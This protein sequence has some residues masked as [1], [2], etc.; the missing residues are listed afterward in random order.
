MPIP[1]LTTQLLGVLMALA[2]AAT[3]GGSDFS[4]GFASRYNNSILVL[5]V[6]AGS[7]LAAMLVL[8]WL[9]PKEALSTADAFWAA[10][11][12]VAGGLGLVFLYRGL[13]LGSA[14]LVSPTAAV[15]GAGLP[16]LA[17]AI[18]EGLPSAL[19]FLGFVV[20]MGGIWLVSSS[21][22]G[23]SD[24]RRLHKLG[25]AAAA[26][27]C[28]GGFYISLSQVA[29][30]HV[31]APLAVTKAVQLILASAAIWLSRMKLNARQGLWIALLAGVLDAGGNS[32]Y[33]LAQQLTRLDVAA[34]LASMYPAGT[35]LLSKL[36]NKEEINRKQWLGVALCLAA[37]GLIAF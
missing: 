7:G 29:D 4:G 27:L 24:D 18:L 16:V 26:G 12:G 19:Q 36:V 22:D 14:A 21:P 9:L 15:I 23:H 17:G 34:V 33:L 25:L 3:W 31:F 32:L 28:F 2:A 8:A 30:G 11:A 35:V 13:A 5:G 37:V 20:G 10:V 6:A 1:V